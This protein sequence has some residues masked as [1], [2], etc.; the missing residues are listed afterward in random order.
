V[1]VA[2]LPFSGRPGI[3]E[4]HIS[5]FKTE[6]QPPVSVDRDRPVFF[7][8]AFQWMQSPTG[9]VDIFGAACVAENSQLP[10]QSV[11]MPR[12]NAILFPGQKKMF[13]SL[14]AEIPYHV[15]IVSRIVTGINVFDCG[16]GNI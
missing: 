14:V 12:L 11:G 16:V 6:S 4:N 7:Q 8:A 1:A 3:K 15:A 10:R 9:E 2:V 13:Q 5:L